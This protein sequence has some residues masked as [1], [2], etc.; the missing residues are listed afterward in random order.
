MG[1][2]GIPTYTFYPEE[3]VDE[4]SSAGLVVRTLYGCQGLGAHLQE[5]NLLALMD[6]AERWQS[7]QQVLLDTC[8]HPNIVGVSSHLLAV[9]SHDDMN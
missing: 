6:D 2:N 3:L 1:P 9:A 8:D 4:L 7:W 5:D